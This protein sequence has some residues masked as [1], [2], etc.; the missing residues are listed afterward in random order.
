MEIKIRSGDGPVRTTFRR[1]Q[2]RCWHPPWAFYPDWMC[3]RRKRTITCA[4]QFNSSYSVGRLKEFRFHNGSRPKSL[5]RAG[6]LVAILPTFDWNSNCPS[7]LKNPNQLLQKQLSKVPII[8][9]VMIESL[10]STKVLIVGREPDDP[11]TGTTMEESD[12]VYLTDWAGSSIIENNMKM[13][14]RQSFFK[15]LIGF[16]AELTSL[17]WY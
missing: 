4:A 1:V 13:E 9:E 14:E 6:R 5:A 16:W 15:W 12:N 11:Q 7:F 8:K 2:V 10:S 17:D 3:A